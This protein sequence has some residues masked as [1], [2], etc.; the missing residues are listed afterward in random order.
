MWLTP[1]QAGAKRV[2]RRVRAP[3]TNVQFFA[4]RI[5]TVVLIANLARRNGAGT[6]A[7]AGAGGA[8]D[9]W[10]LTELIAG[11]LATDDTHDA[12]YSQP[13]PTGR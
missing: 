11:S 6:L 12:S 5:V 7:F 2:V 8:L 3:L 4:A 10:L 1:G 9:D 13:P